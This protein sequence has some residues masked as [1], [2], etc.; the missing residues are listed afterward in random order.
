MGRT[1]MF[2]EKPET[3]WKLKLEKHFV[4]KTAT[5]IETDCDQF[6]EVNTYKIKGKLPGV[7]REPMEAMKQGWSI[8]KKKG[9]GNVE[10]RT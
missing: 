9:K 2:W 5:M 8:W 3:E 10:E 6:M 4:W 7:G 1:S